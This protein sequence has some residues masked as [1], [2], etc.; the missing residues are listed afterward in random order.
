MNAL[1]TESLTLAVHGGHAHLS[2]RGK[3]IT[4]DAHHSFV[5]TGQDGGHVTLHS[6]TE[7]GRV[8]WP[9][10]PTEADQVWDELFKEVPD[11]RN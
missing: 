4:V 5:M 6:V 1:T 3:T 7:M 9:L 8:S 2:M 11:A 10:E